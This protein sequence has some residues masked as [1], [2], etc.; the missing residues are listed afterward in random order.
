MQAVWTL[1]SLHYGQ[2]R[3]LVAYSYIVALCPNKNDTCVSKMS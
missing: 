1:L 3:S 2:F